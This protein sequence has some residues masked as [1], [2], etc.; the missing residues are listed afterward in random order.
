MSSGPHLHIALQKVETIAQRFEIDISEAIHMRKQAIQLLTPNEAKILKK[1]R[2]HPSYVRDPY[3]DPL[4]HL[5]KPVFAIPFYP[6]GPAALPI[7]K[8]SVWDPS[9][10]DMDH[11]GMPAYPVSQ[12]LHRFPVDVPVVFNGQ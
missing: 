5:N 4:H 8:T 9:P 6:T 11:L 7:N 1:A 12:W 2:K 10:V 3:F